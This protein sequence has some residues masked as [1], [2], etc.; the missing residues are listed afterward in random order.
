M[1]SELTLRRLL[2]I[3][4]RVGNL[5]FGGGDPTMA[6][7]H[8]ELVTRRRWLTPEQ[9]ALAF[10]LARVTPGTNLLAFYAAVGWQLVGWR[11]SVGMVLAA[12]VPSAVLVVLLTHSAAAWAGNSLVTSILEALSATAVGMTAA[13]S[14]LLLR[15]H[16][17]G[18]RALR[19]LVF[20][21]AAA[22]LTLGAWL[23]PVQILGLAA[24]AGL[25]W[26]EEEA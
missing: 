4:L 16:L 20:S 17:A 18:R 5:T 1:G 14:W 8:R 26:Q 6:A 23:S 22:V 15:P 3:A 21:G 13:T 24:L 7:F 12:T 9:Y 10:G 2:G 19:A 25:L 11:G